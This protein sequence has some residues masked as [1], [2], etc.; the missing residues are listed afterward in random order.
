M[1]PAFQV[2]GARMADAAR[3][4][5]DTDMAFGGQSD[6]GPDALTPCVSLDVDEDGF[7][8]SGDCGPVDCNDEQASINPEAVELCNGIDD[9]C[10]GRTDE[11]VVSAPCGTGAC[12]RTAACVSGSMD[13]CVPGEPTPEI[14]NQL[15]DDCDGVIDNNLGVNVTGFD[16]TFLRENYPECEFELPIS[17]QASVSQMPCR[18]AFH[19]ACVDQACGQ[20]G[21]GPVG[22]ADGQVF[23]TCIPHTQL[24]AFPL[25]NLGATHER[26]CE[27]FNQV[28]TENCRAAMFMEC[29]LNQGT[30]GGFGPVGRDGPDVLMACVSEQWAT[31]V[32]IEADEAVGCDGE[33]IEANSEGVPTLCTS[34]Y[35]QACVNRGFTSGFGPI[36]GDPWGSGNS[37]YATLCLG[38]PKD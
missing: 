37:R 30:E 14:C 33:F 36:Y 27:A 12:T 18:K 6:A 29:R 26:N 16:H 3:D 21:F 24:H 35:H 13:V 8:V 11:D 22:E 15:D 38:S 34:I 10:D 23:L 5:G 25:A 20:T 2:A 28:N 19:Q 7:D 9:D 1:D 32:F 4:D 17:N 31:H